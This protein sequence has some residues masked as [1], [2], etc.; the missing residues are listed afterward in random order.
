MCVKEVVA[1]RYPMSGSRLTVGQM[2]MLLDE[3]QMINSGKSRGSGGSG[4][5]GGG[6]GVEGSA[7]HAWRTAGED[8]TA[9]S[10]QAPGQGRQDQAAARK[11]EKQR[12]KKTKAQRQAGWVEKLMKCNMSVSWLS[13]LILCV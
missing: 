2:N 4:N 12:Q 13:L 9:E 6:N 3:L 1:E 5:S 11:A 8:G 10:A 7:A